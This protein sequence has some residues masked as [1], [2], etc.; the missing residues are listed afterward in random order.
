MHAVRIA[1][2]DEA[3]GNNNALARFAMQLVIVA[4]P[5]RLCALTGPASSPDSLWRRGVRSSRG[6]GEV[7]GDIVESRFAAGSGIAVKPNRAT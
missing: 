7:R 2:T 1:Q 4:A 5:S 6:T 3:G